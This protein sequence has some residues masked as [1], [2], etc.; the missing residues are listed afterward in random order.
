MFNQKFN[1]MGKKILS[2]VVLGFAVVGVVSAFKWGKGK[3]QARKA[4]AA[5]PV[6]K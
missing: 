1:T 6:K 3:M 5:A 2:V 4:M